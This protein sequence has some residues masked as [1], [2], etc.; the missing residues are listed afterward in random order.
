[1]I[2][3]RRE[4]KMKCDACNKMKR[5]R[6]YLKTKCKMQNAKKKKKKNNNNNNNKM[7]KDK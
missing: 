4:Q 1:M 5:E 3:Q 7:Q 6:E 2:Q